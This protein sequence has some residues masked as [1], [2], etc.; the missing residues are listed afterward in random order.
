MAIIS[1][2]S[3]NKSHSLNQSEAFKSLEE[4]ALETNFPVEKLREICNRITI[5]IFSLGDKDYIL[6]HHLKKIY[7]ILK[8]PQILGKIGSLDDFYLYEYYPE[9]TEYLFFH[10]T[11]DITCWL[12]KLRY[13][14]KET[15]KKKKYRIDSIL[16]GFL[17]EN[18]ISINK[19]RSSIGKKFSQDK[20][21]FHLTKGW[22]N[23]LVRLVP[24]PSDFLEVGTKL[25]TSNYVGKS[26]SWNIIQ[27]YYSIYEYTNSIVFTNTD[28]LRTEQHRKSTSF[29]NN[30]L[31]SK[32]N[33]TTIFYP[34]NISTA[35]KNSISILR[36]GE[37]D[38]WKYKY[39]KCPRF[40]E[41][42]IY[43]LENM[44][45]D[46]MAEHGNVL[47]FMYKFRVWA[48]Y[49]GIS[50]IIEIEEGHLLCFLY[51]NLSLLCFFYAVM[52]ELTAIAFLGEEKTVQL[53]RELSEKYIFKQSNLRDNW[54][55][56]P[57]FIRFRLY[58]KHGFVGKSIDFLVPPN[59]DPLI[60]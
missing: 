51:K 2:S 14:S 41:K 28:N 38:F 44:Y 18:K 32:M 4:I 39:S 12:L 22:Y 29:F 60:L 40:P 46:F 16:D 3:H 36:G 53:L 56:I 19:I 23:E 1:A 11:I 59:P 57:Q 31:F 13:S 17:R 15:I 45:I 7:L 54:Y 52:A 8:N 5:K 9:I 43:D 48:N 37:K 49:L 20:F 55:L 6:K 10:D 27:T 21:I 30:N 34:F 26:P 33:N 42:S 47:D 25:E 35:H 24:V 50:T 58:S